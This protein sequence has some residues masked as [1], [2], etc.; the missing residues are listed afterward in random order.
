MPAT[1]SDVSVFID[2]IEMPMT[3]L[4][5][6]GSRGAATGGHSTGELL[7]ALPAGGTAAAD[8]RWCRLPDRISVR[9]P[10]RT[11]AGC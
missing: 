2:I 10:R 4:S 7:P 3:P 8:D 5:Y 1:E 9:Y 11:I 6:A